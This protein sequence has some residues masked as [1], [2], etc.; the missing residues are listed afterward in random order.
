MDFGQLLDRP[1]LDRPSYWIQ[2]IFGFLFLIAGFW[3]IVDFPMWQL[4]LAMLATGLFVAQ[5]RY[6][7][8]WL[9][10]I[11]ILLPLLDLA[12]WSGRL[13]LDEFDA[14]LAVLTASALLSGQYQHCESQLTRSTYY[15]VW[16]LLLSL[17]TSMAIGMLPLYELDAN[18]WYGYLSGWNAV[19]VGKGMLW[20][21]ILLPLLLRQMTNT[22]D[23]VERHFSIGIVIG[24]A[25]FGLVVLWEKGLFSDVLTASNVWGLFSSWL[26]LSGRYRI[27]GL[28][29]QMHFGGEA[30][31]GYLILAWPFAL[32]LML[33][34][35]KRWLFVVSAL[36]LALAAYAVTMTFTRATYAAVGIAFVIFAVAALRRNSSDSEQP[37]GMM[38][39][40]TVG[41][42]A[43]FIVGYKFGG[44]YALAGFLAGLI[45]SLL[46][47]VYGGPLIGHRLTLA[48]V[49][50]VGVVSAAISAHGMTSSK[51]TDTDGLTALLVS[52]PSVIAICAAGLYIGRRLAGRI[53]PRMLV[54]V[55]GIVSLLLGLGTMALSGY[56]MEA[57]STTIYEDLQV[58]WNHWRQGVGLMPEGMTPTV[59]GSGLGTFPISSLTGSAQAQEHGSYHFLYPGPDPVLRLIGNGDL[60][61]AQRLAD[62]DPGVYH[63]R[64]LARGVSGQPSLDVSVKNRSLLEQFRYQPG[65]A[66]NIPLGQSKS[67]LTEFLLDIDLSDVATTPWYDPAYLMLSFGNG[68]PN[69]SALDIAEISLIDKQGNN[70]LTNPDFRQGGDHWLPYN[71]YQHL[72]WHLKNFYVNVYFD[73]GLLGLLAFLTLLFP[74]FMR[75]RRHASYGSLFAVA[76]LAA[77]SGFLILGLVSTLLDVPRLMTLFLLLAF[78]ALWR[79]R[80]RASHSRRPPEPA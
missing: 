11:P 19:R 46:L 76:L 49:I 41:A 52:I 5:F 28:F 24:L 78:M 56:R 1:E 35:D 27:T 69:D 43:L 62:V 20:A 16:L 2:A 18:A 53:Q 48:A 54:I 15:P 57:R 6:R 67:T 60:R 39:A 36:A 22:R 80:M 23:E 25:G 12:P 71:D 4:P 44:S 63:L 75:S 34:A 51:W 72:A 9:L 30:I 31:D 58:R 47:G 77:L 10:A 29:S 8:T 42:L 73:Q 7:Y 13:L 38:T 32:Y 14:V 68:G 33:K 3:L 50:A 37:L 17:L 59:L 61:F 55:L 66:E 70:L 45:G 21:Y 40:L 64:V 65:I 74:G 79:R 26:D